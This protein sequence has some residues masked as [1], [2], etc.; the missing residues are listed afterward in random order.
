[1]LGG[2]LLATLLFQPL[3]T[4]DSGS[5]DIRPDTYFKTLRRQMRFI[6]GPIHRAACILKCVPG[7]IIVLLAT[8]GIAKGGKHTFP[9]FSIVVER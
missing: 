2:T 4:T 5:V 9:K 3:K 8:H 7:Q 6:T 1:M